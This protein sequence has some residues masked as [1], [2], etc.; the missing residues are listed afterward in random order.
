MAE[1]RILIA[2][3]HTLVCEGLRKLVEPPYQVVGMVADGRALLTA[4]VTLA[5]D[6]ILLDVGMPLLNG[7]D[8]GRQLKAMLPKLKLIYLTMNPDCDLAIEAFRFGASAYLLKSAEGPELLQAIQDVLRGKTF[9]GGSVGRELDARRSSDPRG[10]HC[11]RRLTE[12]QREVLQLIA[13]GYSMEQVALILNI[14]KRTV[15]FHKYRMMEDFGIGN[16]ADLVRFAMAQHL[17]SAA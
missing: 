17:V 13:E 10:A 4:A 12:R 8:A 5:P 16:N 3:D 6:V 9:K 14:S 2:D 11:P 7:L 15:A 1:P